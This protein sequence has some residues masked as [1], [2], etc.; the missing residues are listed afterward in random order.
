M[1]SVNNNIKESPKRKYM[2]AEAEIKRERERV[3]YLQIT[4][5]RESKKTNCKR[6]QAISLL[7][8]LPTAGDQINSM[9]LAQT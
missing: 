8:D 2:E 9:R 3:F 1:K 4:V 5:A 6:K 7:R